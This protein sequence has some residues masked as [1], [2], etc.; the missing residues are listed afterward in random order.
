MTLIVHKETLLDQY[1]FLSKLM[2]K[3]KWKENP[4]G[5]IY[6]GKTNSSFQ[7]M[8]NDIVQTVTENPI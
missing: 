2:K 3:T 7:K 4:F 5:K 8:S 6:E 1:S